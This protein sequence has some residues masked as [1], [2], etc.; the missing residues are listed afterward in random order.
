MLQSVLQTYLEPD[1]TLKDLSTEQVK[2]LLKFLVCIVLR[3]FSSSNS[4]VLFPEGDQRKTEQFI[5]VLIRDNPLLATSLKILYEDGGLSLDDRKK[6]LEMGIGR[7][8]L[9]KDIEEKVLFP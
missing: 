9:P 5:E 6:L 4:S 1:Q 8:L 7:G 2:Y 3:N